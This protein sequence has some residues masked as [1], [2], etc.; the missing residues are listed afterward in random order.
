MTEVFILKKKIWQTMLI[1][2]WICFLVFESWFFQGYMGDELRTVAERPE[3]D[4]FASK[5]RMSLSFL[6]KDIYIDGVLIRNYEL[7]HPIVS[8]GGEFWFP[9]TP[10]WKLRL[11]FEMDID[12]EDMILLLE[13]KFAYPGSISDAQLAVNDFNMRYDAEV[14]SGF[15]LMSAENLYAHRSK[16]RL[17]M[18]LEEEDFRRLNLYTD[19]FP[20]FFTKLSQLRVKFPLAEKVFTSLGIFSSLERDLISGHA[21]Y[22]KINDCIYLPLSWFKSSKVFGWSSHYDNLTGLYISTNPERQASSWFSEQN[23]SFIAGCAEYMRGWNRELS[24]EDAVYFEYLFRHESTVYGIPQ[25]FLMAVCRGEGMFRPEVIGG[26]AIGMMQIMPRT[27]EAQGYSREMLMDPHYNIQ[28]GAMYIRNFMRKYDGDIIKTMSAYNQGSGTVASGSY[29]TDYA[30][31][32]LWHEENIIKWL[33]N[34]GYATQF[35]DDLR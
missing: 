27:G 23:A 4:A 25:T 15:R 8:G 1:V 21:S 10:L 13:D 20:E 6:C 33:S 9:A 5:E 28:F 16:S 35:N 14:H 19:K 22:V 34:R 2:I 24:F 32:I 30:Y 3:A 18:D 11:G 26:G 12:R 17:L 29:R 7:T 31:R